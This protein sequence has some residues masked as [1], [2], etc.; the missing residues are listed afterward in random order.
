MQKIGSKSQKLDEILRF[1]KLAKLRFC[2]DLTP[3]LSC[4][5]LNF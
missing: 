2:L 1:E 4:I 5:L 3:E